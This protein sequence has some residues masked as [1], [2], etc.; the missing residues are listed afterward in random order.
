VRDQGRAAGELRALA[1][2]DL[3]ITELIALGG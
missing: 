1:S 2:A 3:L